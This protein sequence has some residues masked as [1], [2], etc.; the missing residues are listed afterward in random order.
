MPDGETRHVPLQPNVSGFLSG[1]RR[2]PEPDLRDYSPRQ[3]EGRFILKNFGF[4]KHAGRRF[5]GLLILMS[6]LLSGCDSSTG[7]I[8]LPKNNPWPEDIGT[9]WSYLVVASPLSDVDTLD[10]SIVDTLAN[11]NGSAYRIWLK[12]Y[13]LS[14][15]VDSGFV[16]TSGD[17]VFFQDSLSPTAWRWFYLLNA[18]EGDQWNNDSTNGLVSDSTIVLPRTDLTV[19]AGIF[20]DVRQYSRTRF[21]DTLFD[22]CDF[23]LWI[24]PGIGILKRHHRADNTA[25]ASPLPLADTTWTLIAANTD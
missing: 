17:T 3:T 13:R 16:Y 21:P 8:P 7:G 18:E 4:T 10:I 20:T 15:V 6:A 22:R 5:A 2:T 24:S 12:T 1:R 23:T 25:S 14:H 9:Q 11:P 19:P